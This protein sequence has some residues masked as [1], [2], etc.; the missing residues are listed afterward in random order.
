MADLSATGGDLNM[1]PSSNLALKMDASQDFYGGAL[2]ALDTGDGYAEHMDDEP[3]LCFMGICSQFQSSDASRNDD[4]NATIVSGQNPAKIPLLS[5]FDR[6]GRNVTVT[7]ATAVTDHG[8]LVFATDDATMTLT[9]P[10]DD[11]G[12]VGI[13]W[14]YVSTGVCHVLFFT[15]MQSALMTMIGTHASMA[16]CV[17]D[18][19]SWGT[20]VI[21]DRVSWGQHGL[22]ESFTFQVATSHTGATSTVAA[23]AAVNSGSDIFASDDIVLAVAS[24]VGGYEETTDE[25]VVAANAEFHDGDTINLSL[26]DG[27]NAPTAGIGFVT[28]NYK[29]LIGV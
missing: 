19:A 9:A 21:Y 10:A 18:I 8:K 29:R 23:N 11:R 16:F 15:P 24:A 2:I 17:Y 27:A 13:V 5:I 3:G 26:L 4:T 20:G 7:G 28:M 12:A 22:I 14:E 6:L 1:G 25:A